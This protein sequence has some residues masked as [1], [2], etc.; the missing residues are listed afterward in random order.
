VKKKKEHE[1]VEELSQRKQTVKLK[2]KATTHNERDKI[3]G[4]NLA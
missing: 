4:G 3:K 2:T 1:K